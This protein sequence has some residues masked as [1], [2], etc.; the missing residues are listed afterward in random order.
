MLPSDERG[1]R[2]F[3]DGSSMCGRI[4]HTA[5]VADQ[6]AEPERRNMEI[7]HV[8]NSSMRISPNPILPPDGEPAFHTQNVNRISLPIPKL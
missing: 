3:S 6:T 8:W 4:A 2:A 5:G 7:S 1:D